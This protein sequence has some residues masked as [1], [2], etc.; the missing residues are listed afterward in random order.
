MLQGNGY[1]CHGLS[2]FKKGDGVR[3]RCFKKG[4]GVATINKKEM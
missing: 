3:E 4:D 1:G 2:R